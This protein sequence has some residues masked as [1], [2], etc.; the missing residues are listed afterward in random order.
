MTGSN[1]V[2][3]SEAS[4]STPTPQDVQ[5]AACSLPASFQSARNEPAGHCCVTLLAVKN[6]GG[7]SAGG[8]NNNAT[9]DTARQ[10]QAAHMTHLQTHACF[11]GAQISDM[12]QRP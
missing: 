12:Q 10:A 2:K 6:P 4:A 11:L 9:Q 8:N 3:R 7:V 1:T 5:L